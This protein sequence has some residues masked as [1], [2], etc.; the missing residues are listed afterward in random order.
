MAMDRGA[1]VEVVA[2]LVDA[3]TGVIRVDEVPVDESEH[4]IDNRNP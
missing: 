3:G 2:I 4:P 1:A